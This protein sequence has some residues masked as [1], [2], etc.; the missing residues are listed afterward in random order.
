M[1]TVFNRIPSQRRGRASGLLSLLTAFSVT[2][3]FLGYGALA[4]YLVPSALALS[5]SITEQAKSHYAP[6]GTASQLSSNQNSVRA[7]TSGLWN[8]EG[9]YTDNPDQFSHC[10]EVAA[11]S[12]KSSGRIKSYTPEW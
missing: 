5:S 12:V 6:H 1:R 8:C 10:I 7:S 4:F 11:P 3:L 9:S 2:A